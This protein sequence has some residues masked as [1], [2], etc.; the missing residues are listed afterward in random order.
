[1]RLRPQRAMREY[2]FMRV[3]RY[4]VAIWICFAARLLFYSAML[5]LWEGYDEWAHFAVIRAMAF[6]GEVLVRRESFIPRDVDAS[7]KIVPLP[8]A[9]RNLPPPS[10]TEDVYWRLP[11]SERNRREIE[12]RSIP[13]S[14]AAERSGG[15]LNAYEA[16]QPPLYYWLMTPPLRALRDTSL[17]TQVFAIRILSSLLASCA[18]PLIFRL[19]CLVFENAAM[20]AA[21]SAVPAAMP[22]FAIDVARVGNECIAV[23]LFTLLTVVILTCVRRGINAQGAVLLGAVLGLGLL[24]KAYFLAAI[25]PVL[26]L[27]LY[28]LWRRKA[29]RRSIALSAAAVAAIALSISGWWYVRNLVTTGTLSGLTE[30]VMLRGVGGGAMLRG[31]AGVPWLRGV[32]S[33][34]LSHLWFGGWSA[35]TARAWMYHVFYVA[36]PIALCGV[37]RRLRDPVM[38]APAAIY[39][40][41]W[42]GELYNVLLLY[43]SKHAATSMGWYLYAVVGAEVALAVGGLQSILPG[44]LARWIAPLGVAMFAVFDLYTVNAVS[45]PYYTGMIAHKADGSLAALHA[46]DAQRLGFA[47]TLSRMGA[48]KPQLFT[49]T[50]LL[51]IWLAH[52]VCTIALIFISIA[53]ARRRGVCVPFG[54]ANET[55]SS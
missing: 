34:I 7:L 41:F 17:S 39:G 38:L 37:V 48:Y 29:P 1:M 25:P 18:I 52:I 42:I 31:A 13:A 10:V 23:I 11:S 2:P 9:L 6:Q 24:A 53:L 47:E 44:G 50:P 40:C 46:A 12:F 19:G 36:I 28:E 26:A 4:V 3:G 14:W 51:S 45:I 15:P 49:G 8:W 54:Y 33:I 20:A 22:E 55:G 5:P 27:L 30:A 35:L 32:D 43:M 16:L 21:C